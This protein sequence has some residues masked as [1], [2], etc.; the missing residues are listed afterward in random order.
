MS[1][2]ISCARHAVQFFDSFTAA[3]YFPLLTPAHHVEGQT[4]IIAVI[5]GSAFFVADYL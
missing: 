2:R 3:G 1:N 5:G 4:G